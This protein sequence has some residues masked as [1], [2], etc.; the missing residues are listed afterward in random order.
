MALTK[1]DLT[2]LYNNLYSSSVTWDGMGG[3]GSDS[4][5][6]IA[7]LLNILQALDS[8][9]SPTPGA[10]TN[11]PSLTE[12]TSAD[13]AVTLPADTYSEV[14]IFVTQSSTGTIDSVSAIANVA[15]T[16]TS[17]QNKTLDEINFQVSTGSFQ[18]LTVAI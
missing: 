18:V 1:T 2:T 14:S 9:F 8:S 6:I 11:T 16:F 17:E 5:R 15:Y 10:N 3:N 4:R 13:G 7:L 12:Y